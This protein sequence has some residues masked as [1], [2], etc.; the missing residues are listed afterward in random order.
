[1][2]PRSEEVQPNNRCLTLSEVGAFI[3]PPM[4]IDTVRSEHLRT[5][6]E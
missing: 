1:M 4:K 5:W 2:R 6:I 3:R